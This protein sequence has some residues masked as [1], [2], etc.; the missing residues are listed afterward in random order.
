MYRKGWRYHRDSAIVWLLFFL[1]LGTAGYALRH[2]IYWIAVLLIWAI[3]TPIR[4]AFIFAHPIRRLGWM[5]ESHLNFQEIT[6]QSRDGLTLFGR[7]VRSKNHAT[8]LLLHPLNSA[9]SKMLLYAEFL[10]RAGYGVFMID[11]RAHGS[12]DGDTSTDGWR[13]ADDVAGAVDYLLHRPDVNG[14]KIGALGISLGAQAV[15]RG[16]LKTDC[17]RALVLEGLGPV[18]LSDHGGR[19]RSL[20]RWLHYPFHWIYY[21][22]Y[23]FMIR[24]RDT[25]VTEA[26]GKIAPRPVLLIASGEKDIY[27]NRI[28]F[29]AAGEPKELWEL[30]EGEHAAAILHDSQAYIERVVKFFNRTL[31]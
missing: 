5:P 14:Q 8:L 2:P 4:N 7:F 25:S 1:L 12:S 21:R 27:F 23:E 19:P 29:Q 6:F 10:A 3:R 22:V 26:I 20:R 16:A 9:G 24:G 18:T 17:L 11:L 15:L 28:F 13:E 30:P 31:L